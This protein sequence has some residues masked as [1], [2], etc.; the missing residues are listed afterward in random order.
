[1]SDRAG[2]VW[3]RAFVMA[4]PPPG[5]TSGERIRAA[6]EVLAEDLVI[7]LDALHDY[8]TAADHGLT[9]MPGY[10]NI[11]SARALLARYPEGER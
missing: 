11:E 4:Q 5:C 10:S 6:A 2:E 8:V 1:M 3:E 7:A 9:P